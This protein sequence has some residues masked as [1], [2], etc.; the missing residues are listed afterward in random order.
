MACASASWDCRCSLRCCCMSTAW[1]RRDL[2]RLCWRE[3]MRMLISLAAW[4]AASR[5][6]L[7]KARSAVKSFWL[8][9]TRTTSACR[10]L[11]SSSCSCSIASSAWA[12]LYSSAH[13]VIPSLLMQ[14]YKNWQ[15]I[16]LTPIAWWFGADTSRTAPALDQDLKQQYDWICLLS[17]GWEAPDASAKGHMHISKISVRVY[18]RRNHITSFHIHWT[19][20]QVPKLFNKHTRKPQ[21]LDST[22]H[23][24]PSK[25][26][27]PLHWCHSTQRET[28]IY[29]CGKCALAEGRG[30]VCITPYKHISVW[31]NKNHM[32]N[33]S[34]PTNIKTNKLHWLFPC[35]SSTN[36]AYTHNHD[37]MMCFLRFG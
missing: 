27:R 8:A 16:C 21:T 28:V 26:S 30:P 34:L 14:H 18:Q 13:G 17:I 33:H 29:D 10:K 24:Q 31:F 6:S 2:S 19:A 11:P 35:W 9:W 12:S 37:K 22:N 15:L 7:T 23:G 4:F 32:K 20:T 36:Q 3:T 5:S 1:H 25:S